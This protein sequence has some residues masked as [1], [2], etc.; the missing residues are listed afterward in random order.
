MEHARAPP[1]GGHPSGFVFSFVDV[2]RHACVVSPSLRRLRC[3][4]TR[5]RLEYEFP[6]ILHS[7]RVENAV[8]MIYLMLYN[9]GMKPACRTC[10]FASIEIEPAVANVPRTL[11]ETPEARHRKTSFPTALGLRVDDFD[12]RIYEYGQRRGLVEPFVLRNAGI[13][14]I[15]RRLEYHHA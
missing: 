5:F 13:G 15:L 6:Q 9:A 10:D 3:P 1:G 8:E 14:S 2:A 7:L 11:N 4:V 12:L